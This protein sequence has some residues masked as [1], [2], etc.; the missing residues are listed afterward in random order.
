M[1]N[2]A[3]IIDR[4]NLY[5]KDYTKKKVTSNKTDKNIKITESLVNILFHMSKKV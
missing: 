3:V 4:K 2:Y 1:S 5:S